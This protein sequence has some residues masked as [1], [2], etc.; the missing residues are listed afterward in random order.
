[1]NDVQLPPILLR[2]LKDPQAASLHG[3]I[4]L[5]FSL[6]STPEKTWNSLVQ[7]RWPGMHPELLPFAITTGLE[8]YCLVYRPWDRALHEAPVVKFSAETYTAM[9]IAGDVQGFLVWLELDFWRR[10]HTDASFAAAEG[11]MAN[12][13]QTL[14]GLTDL[15]RGDVIPRESDAS[16][17]VRAVHERMV[18]LD[19]RAAGSWFALAG[20][21]MQEERWEEAEDAL[22]RA[23]RSFPLFSAAQHL[24]TV[25]ALREN[26]TSSA[27][28]RLLALMGMPWVWAPDRED[29]CFAHVPSFEPEQIASDYLVHTGEPQLLESDASATSAWLVNRPRV[30]PPEW[31]QA[32]AYFLELRDYESALSA[33]SN[34]LLREPLGARSKDALDACARIYG[35]S[36]YPEL[37]RL[38]TAA[39]RTLRR[40]KTPPRAIEGGHGRVPTNH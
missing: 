39:V 1:M 21:A 33:A 15:D 2:W 7:Q 31:L 40:W 5:L 37:Q 32:Y 11:E 23:L 27:R 18:E 24:R 25:V 38:A 36:R 20:Y 28:R 4:R 30:T 17:A 12:S 6:G 13:L 14:F 34:A 22:D 8:L 29:V 9:P 16:E 26:R 19:P 10:R 3:P 35:Q